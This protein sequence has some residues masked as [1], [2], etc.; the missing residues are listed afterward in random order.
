MPKKKKTHWFLAAVK[1]TSLEMLKNS[2]DTGLEMAS[3]CAETGA[4]MFNNVSG[5]KRN[6]RR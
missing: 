5:G 6:R 4:E 3:N 2:R 1:E